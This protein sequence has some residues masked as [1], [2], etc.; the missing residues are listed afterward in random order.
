LGAGEAAKGDRLE[1]GHLRRLSPRRTMSSVLRPGSAV[2]ERLVLTEED[3]QARIPSG[4]S[5]LASRLSGPPPT[6]TRRV[7]SPARDVAWSG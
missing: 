5:L 2:S 6:C 1:D 4:T 3:L 7:F